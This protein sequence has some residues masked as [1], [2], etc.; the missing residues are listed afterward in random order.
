MRIFEVLPSYANFDDIENHNAMIRMCRIR[1]VSGGREDRRT[2]PSW[3]SQPRRL[4][5]ECDR[6]RPSGL[7][8][9]REMTRDE[10]GARTVLAAK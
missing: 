1:T 10:T 5:Y 6:D 9:M 2:D 7:N 8:L 3:E 4:V